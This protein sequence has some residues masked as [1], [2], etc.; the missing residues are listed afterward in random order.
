MPTITYGRTQVE[1]LNNWKEQTIMAMSL[2]YQRQKET[3]TESTLGV[4][5]NKTCEQISHELMIHFR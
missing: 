2:K 3:N 5:T 1:L 4:K